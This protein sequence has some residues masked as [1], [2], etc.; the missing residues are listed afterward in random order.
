MSTCKRMWTDREVRSMADE[1]AK[2]RIEAGQTSNA[3]PIYLHP[4]TVEFNNGEA[5]VGRITM[6]IFNNSATPFEDMSA[7]LTYIRSLELVNAR[8]MVSGGINDVTRS[9]I[10]IA[11]VMDVDSSYARI[12]GITTSGL[13]STGLIVN[14]D[15]VNFFDD[16]VNKIN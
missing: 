6:M 7:L 12:Y 14:T 4:I 13:K 10:V 1:S 2:I 11:S 15:D 16:A 3:K 9:E 5:N 8:I